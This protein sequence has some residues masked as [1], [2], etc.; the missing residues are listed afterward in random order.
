MKR[1]TAASIVPPAQRKPR[2][3]VSERDGFTIALILI[4]SMVAGAD[5][6]ASGALVVVGRERQR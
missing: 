5:Y 4:F 2:V 3:V 6:G 1:Q